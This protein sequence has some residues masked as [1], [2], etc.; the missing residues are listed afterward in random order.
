MKN[1]IKHPLREPFDNI[2]GSRKPETEKG[3][4]TELHCFYNVHDADV[5]GNRDWKTEAGSVLV[6]QK[7]SEQYV[8][9]GGDPE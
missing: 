8:L 4:V 9:P 1:L 5:S 3:A 6:I 2:C 7:I